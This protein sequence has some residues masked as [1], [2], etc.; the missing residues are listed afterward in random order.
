MN[1]IVTLWKKGII[2]LLVIFLINFIISKINFSYLVPLH[3][4][5][6]SLSSISIPLVISL[7]IVPLF[8]AM[9]MQQIDRRVR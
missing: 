8:V 4:E 9:A 3:I 2:L 6:I 5:D 1:Q 7:L